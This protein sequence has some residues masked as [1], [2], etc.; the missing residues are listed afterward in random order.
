MR[1]DG[2][3]S[4]VYRSADG[5]INEL[6]NDGVNGWQRGDISANAGALGSG[7]LAAGD[8]VA[9]VRSD[10]VSTVV[11]RGTDNHIRDLFLD[12]SGWHAEDLWAASGAP[13]AALSTDDLTAYV[14]S[15]GVSSV[16][17]RSTPDNHLRELTLTV[18]PIRIN[19]V[20]VTVAR[21]WSAWD[22]TAQTGAPVSTG[23]PTA[24]VRSD[25]INSV[26]YLDAG[27]HLRELT[28][29]ALHG[30]AWQAWDFYSL[31]GTAAATGDPAGYLRS[32]MMDA[33]VF[34]SADGHTRELRR[35]PDSGWLLTI[36]N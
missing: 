9:Y 10:G 25:N 34:K 15:D 23:R 30:G 32:D 7:L 1:H 17:Y 21:S 35:V 28:L 16:V 29:D 11:Y 13:A 8:P 33:V 20:V 19:G 12:S 2:I 5:H 3:N 14:R 24:Y 18:T 6:F 4:V 36:L 31:T 26:V 27:G 22:L